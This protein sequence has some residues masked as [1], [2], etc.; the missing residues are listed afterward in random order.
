[1]KNNRKIV[2]SLFTAAIMSISMIG[3]GNTIKPEESAQV[4]CEIS[5]KHDI[6]NA[7]K[8][9]ISDDEA[10][11]IID[12]T[13]SEQKKVL[14]TNFDATQLPI[15]DS[16]IDS[17]I[18]AYNEVFNKIDYTIE[19]TSQTS[20]S[21][22]VKISSTYIDLSSI[23]TEA[24]GS[25]LDELYTLDVTS[26]EDALAKTAELY[27]KNLLNGLKDAKAS[28]NTVEKTFTFEK[29]DGYWLPSDTEGF[30]EQL[31]ELMLR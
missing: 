13:E 11:A 7:S 17:V 14:K 9:G 8:L 20:K 1:M 26:E 4:L 23:D 3:C 5:V 10:N 22:Q 2:A 29:A 27:I 24:A 18:E 12:E 16:Q 25:A 21:A 30:A 28:T 15:T 31:Q 19:V 6:T